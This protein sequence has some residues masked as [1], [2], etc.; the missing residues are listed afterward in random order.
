[1]LDST[2]RSIRDRR[3]HPDGAVL[4]DQDAVGPARLGCPQQ[5]AEVLRVLQA[6]QSQQER[7]LAALVGPC[8]KI[9]GV[10]VFEG[11]CLGNN[12]LMVISSS[13]IELTA[14]E[15]L[16]PDA[17]TL[18]QVQERV[19]PVR[20]AGHQEAVDAAAGRQR[21]AD[22]VSTVEEVDAELRESVSQSALDAPGGFASRLV[23]D[24]N[25]EGAELVADLVGKGPLLDVA[26]LAAN[27]EEHRNVGFD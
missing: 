2:G 12:A 25:A 6:I 18:G 21:F 5:R 3:R 16:D 26:Q 19:E 11:V 23:F 7:R 4:G 14:V 24:G 17:S 8:E 1:M 20:A 9:V 22:R 27:V 13:T 10:S 15:H